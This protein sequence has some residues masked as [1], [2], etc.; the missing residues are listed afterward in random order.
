MTPVPTMN[1]SNYPPLPKP[2]S[3]PTQSGTTVVLPGTQ[4]DSPAKLSSTHSST[5][6]RSLPDLSSHTTRPQPQ[7]DDNFPPFTPTPQTSIQDLVKN[8]NNV[9]ISFLKID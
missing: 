2:S 3:P 1:L 9:N 8:T 4:P 5:P 6:T 7:P